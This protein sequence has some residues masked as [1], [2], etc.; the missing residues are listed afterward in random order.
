MPAS[1][2]LELSTVRLNGDVGKGTSRV[3]CCF[4]EGDESLRRNRFASGPM[5]SWLRGLR[6][7]R[8]KQE[9]SE[10]LEVEGEVVS[11][12]LGDEGDEQGR[13]RKSFKYRSAWPLA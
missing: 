6:E 12:E 13:R 10:Q 9:E 1:S 4:L 5:A 7:A 2:V 11:N 8:A 3:E